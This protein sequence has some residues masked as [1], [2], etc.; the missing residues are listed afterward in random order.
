MEILRQPQLVL[1]T[2]EFDKETSEDVQ[3][4]SAQFPRIH[5]S[6]NAALSATVLP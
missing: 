6:L 5:I 3:V 2:P 1:S 4:I